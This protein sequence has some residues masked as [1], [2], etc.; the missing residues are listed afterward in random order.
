MTKYCSAEC[1]RNH[2]HN[3]HRGCKKTLSAEE[4]NRAQAYVSG[5][6]RRKAAREGSCTAG[7]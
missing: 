3:G 7:C 4:A 6:E 2:F 5:H 1:Q